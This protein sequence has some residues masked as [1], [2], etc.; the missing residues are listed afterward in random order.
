MA[1]VGQGL[2]GGPE[3]AFFE[4]ELIGELNDELAIALA[5]SEGHDQDAAEVVRL[6][7]FLARE[8]ADHVVAHRIVLAKHVEVERVDVVVERLVVQEEFR[9]QAQV[10]AVGLLV[11]RINLEEGNLVVAVD[12]VSRRVPHQ[13][14]LRVPH[15][16]LL[17]DEEVQTE[18][19]YVQRLAVVFLRE[20]REVPSLDPVLAELDELDCLDLGGFLELMNLLLC[21]PE[22]LVV[23]EEVALLL[24]LLLLLPLVLGQLSLDRSL[25]EAELVL[26][27]PPVVPALLPHVVHVVIEDARLLHHS[28][29]CLLFPLLLVHAL[30]VVLV[31]S[32]SSPHLYDLDQVV[33]LGVPEGSHCIGVLFEGA[34]EDNFLRSGGA[35]ESFLVRIELFDVL[36]LA[37]SSAALHFANK[38]NYKQTLSLSQGKKAPRSN[39]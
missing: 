32:L 31:A 12:L 33:L 19:A 29:L 22:V 2:L 13:A 14:P 21:E 27:A 24:S 30:K 3:A 36:A 28:V 38:I 9:Y 25:V 37:L 16:L 39:N 20:R 18:L 1:E 35:Y 26:E 5:L 11:L 17:V 34:L 8:V 10:L 15:Q 7:V 4:R 6:V 23:R